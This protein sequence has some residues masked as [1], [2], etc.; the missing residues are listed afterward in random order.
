MLKKIFILLLLIF[1]P[2]I[3]IQAA[4]APDFILSW[5]TD[6]YIPPFYAGKA[7]PITDSYIKVIAT[8]T[9]SSSI[10]INIL[11]FNWFSDNRLISSASGEGKSVYIFKTYKSADSYYEIKLRVLYPDSKLLSEK[12]ILIK[13]AK[14]EIIWQNSDTAESIPSIIN[15]ANKFYLTSKQN[16]N[17][18]AQPLFF[19]IQKLTDLNFFWQFDNQKFEDPSRENQNIFNLTT[20]DISTLTEKILN[21][22]V[23][24]KNKSFEK[25]NAELN[26]VFSP[27]GD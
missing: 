13:I 1:V 5:A 25:N 12:I 11:K 22:V 3:Y 27:L 21:L 17:F 14:P 19:N 16:I 23:I 8:P 15:P 9:F 24:N 6:T 4:Q 18:I 2:Q 20:S 26:L 7:M 10:N